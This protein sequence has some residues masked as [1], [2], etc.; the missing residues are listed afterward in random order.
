[1]RFAVSLQ[2][3]RALLILLGGIFVLVAVALVIY[4]VSS[5]SQLQGYQAGQ[6]TI[7]AK[8]LLQRKQE[9]KEVYSSN[10]TTHTRTTTTT[11][12]Q[13]DFQFMVQTADGRRYAARGYDAFESASSDRASQQAIVDQYSVGK[14]YPCWYDPA[15]PAQAVLTR[16]FNRVLLIIPGVFF[17]VGGMFLI[18]GILNPFRLSS[19]RHFTPGD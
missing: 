12:Y 11:V 5:F 8:Q 19:R 14:T 3:V 9:Q 4:F 1:M 6:C 16:Q 17:F 10:G 2:G 18:V 7:T 13:P 15:R